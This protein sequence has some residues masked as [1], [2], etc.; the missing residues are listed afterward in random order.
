[1]AK[2]PFDDRRSCHGNFRTASLTAVLAFAKFSLGL[3]FETLRTVAFVV[4]VFGNQATTYTREMLAILWRLSHTR[5]MRL[6]IPYSA[7]SRGVLN[8]YRS[9]SPSASQVEPL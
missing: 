3:E 9:G 4:I 2:W 8:W 5:T 6:Q 1:M 7:A